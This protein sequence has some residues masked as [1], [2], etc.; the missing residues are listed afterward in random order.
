MLFLITETFFT[1]RRE[2]KRRLVDFTNEH[3]IDF[4]CKNRLN[5]AARGG[6]AILVK[7]KRGS[8]KSYTPFVTEFEMVS[9]VGNMPGYARKMLLVCSYLPPGMKDS[10]K[11]FEEIIGIINQ[12]KIDFD[13]PFIAVG[14]DF[15]EF[16]ALPITDAFNELK[17]TVRPPTQE[18]RKMNSS[19]PNTRR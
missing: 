4:F 10:D 15:N 3:G 13:D 8:F 7:K 1:N 11:C 2:I 6:A 9:T 18:D 16:G 14:G 17:E 12:A 5:G 19:S